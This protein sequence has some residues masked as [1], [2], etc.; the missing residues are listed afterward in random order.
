MALPGSTGMRRLS[1]AGRRTGLCGSATRAP[2]RAVYA[3]AGGNPIVPQALHSCCRG[4]P[5]S[6][7]GSIFP[8][9]ITAD[10]VNFGGSGGQSP[11]GGRQ[12]E[13]CPPVVPTRSA[14][15][16]CIHAGDR[17]TR[18]PHGAAWRPGRSRREG[19]TKRA[20][21]ARWLPWLCSFDPIL[22]SPFRPRRSL[23]RRL[24]SMRTWRWLAY[25]HPGRNAPEL[26]TG[27]N[28]ALSPD[29]HR[30]A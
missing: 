12:G 10:A 29:R 1:F 28:D 26:A 4:Q 15:G 5:D 8:S 9:R 20:R 22:S 13:S 21:V 17:A 3:D 11:P 18:S 6:T 2:L 7:P 19:Q 25:Y 23:P 30:P 14:G 16:E 27:S 24:R